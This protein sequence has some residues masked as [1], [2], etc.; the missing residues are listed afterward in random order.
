M[1]KSEE[2]KELLQS[3]IQ[4]TENSE[5]ASSQDVINRIIQQLQT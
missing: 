4:Q 3:I 1:T 5:L 2:L